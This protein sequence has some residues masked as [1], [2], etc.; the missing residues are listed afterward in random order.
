MTKLESCLHIV[1]V[2]IDPALEDAFNAWYEQVHIPAL[3]RCPGWLSARRYVSL[4]G[5][6]K[7]V[8]VYEVAGSWVYETPEFHKAKGFMEFE[9][10]VKNFVRLRLQPISASNTAVAN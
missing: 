8:A 1:R 6:P 10:H 4:D 2:D 7:Y 3:L 5:G 9:P